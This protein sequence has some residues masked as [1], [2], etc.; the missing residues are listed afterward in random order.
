MTQIKEIIVIGNDN[1][2]GL[3]LLRWGMVRE[4]PAVL[5]R[6]KC[7]GK[8]KKKNQENPSDQ[9]IITTLWRKH[10]SGDRNKCFVIRM[11]QDNGIKRK[12]KN[13]Y[14]KRKKGVKMIRHLDENC[15][16]NGSREIN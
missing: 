13:K 16:N 12:Y 10:V 6:N 8:K 4:I 11:S 3:Q 1:D 14:A 5:K 7:V 15:I 9:S 2:N